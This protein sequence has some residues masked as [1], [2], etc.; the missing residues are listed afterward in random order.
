[1]YNY[2]QVE[3]ALANIHGISAS[4]KGAFRA[5]IKNFQKLGIVPSSPGK[6]KRIS[7]TPED[8]SMWAFC[9]ELAQ[10]GLDPS[11]I[12]SMAHIYKFLVSEYLTACSDTYEDDEMFFVFFPRMI[13]DW[14][15]SPDQTAGRFFAQVFRRSEIIRNISGDAKESILPRGHLG[16]AC[17]LNLSL[18]RWRLTHALKSAQGN[19]RSS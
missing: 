5:R 7:Y 11:V 18:L 19:G 16:R 6:G 10:F 13:S 3:E 2:G 14:S 8:V 9:L 4:T 15:N 12:K 1:M 17:L